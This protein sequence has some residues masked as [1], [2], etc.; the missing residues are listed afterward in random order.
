MVCPMLLTLA[1]A[2]QAEKVKSSMWWDHA[3]RAYSQDTR[4]ASSQHPGPL[5]LRPTDR[6]ANQPRLPGRGRLKPLLLARQREKSEASAEEGPFGL[7]DSLKTLDGLLGGER[8]ERGDV[9][10][11]ALQQPRSE[12]VPLRRQCCCY[13][14]SAAVHHDQ[15][16]ALIRRSVLC[17]LCRAQKREW[18]EEFNSLTLAQS[19]R[20]TSRRQFEGL[21]P[22]RL[23][24]TPAGRAGC[25]MRLSALVDCEVACARSHLDSNRT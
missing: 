5:R 14:G 24:P 11:P 21:Q 18:N 25:M 13:G 10:A 20:P 9:L 8:G 23:P 19:V 6:G 16:G 17:R 4:A 22:R 1:H 15:G 2:P 12:S 7:Y 3:S